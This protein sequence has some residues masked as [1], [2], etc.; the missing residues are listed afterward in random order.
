MAPRRPHPG[1]PSPGWRARA[2][3]P[4]PSRWL[5]AQPHALLYQAVADTLARAARPLLLS[6]DCTTALGAVAGLQRRKRDVAVVWLDGHGDFNTPATTI[7]G[8]LGGMPLAMLAGRAPRADLR[9]AP[10]AAGGR[11]RRRAR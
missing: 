10:A 2:S 6:G 4:A 8:Y 11:Q 7:T 3:L 1:L 9:P 5:P